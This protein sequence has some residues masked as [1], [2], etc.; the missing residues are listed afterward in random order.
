MSPPTILLIDSDGDSVTVY[1]L[2]LRHHG[3]NVIHAH[4]AEAGLRM[5]MESKPDVVISELFPPSLEGVTLLNQLQ[6]D[7]RTATA[8]LFVLDSVPPRPGKLDKGLT[9]VKRLRKPCEPSRLLQEVQRV[10]E[11]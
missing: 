11:R 4:D 9:R 7:E 3:Y 5:A 1:S 2:I 6:K 8:H 10:L